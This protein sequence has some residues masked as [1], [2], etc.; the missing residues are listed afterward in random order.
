MDYR[1]LYPREPRITL[2]SIL[3]LAV[4]VSAAAFIVSAI[5]WQPWNADDL[6]IFAPST[7]N[8]VIVE[9]A[10]D[11]LDVLVQPLTE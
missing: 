1:H 10:P 6:T 8:T 11:N 5:V 9:P 4:F 7:E 2:T 3:L